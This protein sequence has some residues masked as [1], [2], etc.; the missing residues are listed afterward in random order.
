LNR[1]SRK[2]TESVLRR[3]QKEW[4]SAEKFLI[5]Q[6]EQ[7]KASLKPLGFYNRR[8][9]A[10]VKLAKAFESWDGQEPRELPYIGEY[11]ARAW[12]IF[13]QGKLGADPPEDG[14]LV[15]YWSWAIKLR[16]KDGQ[17]IFKR[18]KEREEASASNVSE[19]EQNL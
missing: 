18:T 7:V 11:A 1:T 13:C 3:F 9:N 14:A 10:L 15:K 2:Q 5:A 8:F 17:K 12:E 19:H 16:N 4:F 6:E